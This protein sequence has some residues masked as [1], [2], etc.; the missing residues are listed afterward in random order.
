MAE[1][2]P[3]TPPLVVPPCR[4]PNP[5]RG[6]RLMAAFLAAVCLA[7]GVE[8]Q[9]QATCSGVLFAEE[10]ITVSSTSL[11]FTAATYAQDAPGPGFGPVTCAVFQVQADAIYVRGTG[12]AAT[13]TGVVLPIYTSSAP[14]WYVSGQTNIRNF[15]MLRVT[16]DSTVRVWYYRGG[17]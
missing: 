16:N 13:N 15:R 8:A 7:F 10:T 17:N 14:L 9:T 12:G 11:P 2:A 3:S 4:P 5:F 6:K 1:D